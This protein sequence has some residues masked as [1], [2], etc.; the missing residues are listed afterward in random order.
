LPDSTSIHCYTDASFSVEWVKTIAKHEPTTARSWTGY[1][2]LYSGCPVVWCS[3][4]Q[5][6]IAL[7][8]TESEYV[9]LSQG[10]REVIALFGILKEIK[11]IHPTINNAI[12]TLHCKTFDDNVGAIEMENCL[13]MR[14]QTKHLTI[15]YHHFRQA[16]TKGDNKIVYVCR[17]L[18][19]ADILTK[20]LRI[21]LLQTLR[22]LIMGRWLI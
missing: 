9:A 21:G 6:E 11:N 13:K 10:L 2:I 19:S 12:P 1:V 5:T 18:Q 22:S 16:V 17:K 7:S 4:L 3:R 20:A 15:K 14:P 8:A